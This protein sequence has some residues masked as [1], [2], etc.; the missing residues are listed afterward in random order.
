MAN[1]SE[2]KGTFK[3]IGDW[4]LRQITTLAYMLCSLENASTDYTTNTNLPFDQLVTDLQADEDIEFYGFGRWSFTSN[5][6][7]FV[8]WSLSSE[9]EWNNQVLPKITTG[10]DKITYREYTQRVIELVSDMAKNKL[11][12]S[13]KFSDIEPGVGLLAE[14]EGYMVSTYEYSTADHTSNYIFKFLVSNIKEHNCNL[15]NQYLIIENTKE[16]LLMP[17][18]KELQKKDITFSKNL[19]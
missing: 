6:E 11:K 4:N 1:I 7:S 3:L 10:P 9:D 15:K 13:W 14:V 8:D 18:S 19:M 12:V 16:I 5:L 17:L 2:A